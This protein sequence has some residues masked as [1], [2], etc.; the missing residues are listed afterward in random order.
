M[1]P[2]HDLTLTI[3]S[4]FA[5]SSLTLWCNKKCT[6]RSENWPITFFVIGDQI[7]ITWSKS[8]LRS[9]QD[10]DLEFP[11]IVIRDKIA[12]ADHFLGRS[13]WNFFWQFFW[14]FSGP[15][16]GQKIFRKDYAK[17]N[18]KSNRFFKILSTKT[19]ILFSENGKYANFQV[20]ISLFPNIVIG[21]KW[22]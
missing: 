8:D 3:S 10:H 6:L 22:S 19:K 18:K 20:K 11:K 12:I 15:S 14:I 9:D 21:K 16:V 17:K 1:P 13:F 7:K 2:G 4:L 5:L